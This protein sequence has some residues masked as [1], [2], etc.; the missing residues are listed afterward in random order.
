MCATCPVFEQCLKGAF[1]FRE[2]YGVWAG[3]TAK[4]RGYLFKKIET[5]EMTEEV[6][7]KDLLEEH[8]GR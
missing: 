1:L 4:Q 3:T 2:R 6:V 7:I 5:G 8:H